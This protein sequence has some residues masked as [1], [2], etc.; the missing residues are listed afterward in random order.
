M[1]LIQVLG[2][3]QSPGAQE[4]ADGLYALNSM[5]D[6]W[7]IERLM[8]YQIQQTT[9]TWPANT[10]SRTIGSGGNFNTTRPTKVV[11]GTFFRD[12]NGY[13]YPVTVTHDRAV[14]DSISLKTSNSTYPDLLF[15]DAAHPLMILYVYPVP[16]GSL[17]LHLNT[18]KQLQNFAALTTDLSLPPGY[19]AAIEHNLAVWMAPEFGKAAKEA[20]KDL[21]PQAALLKS[22]LKNMNQQSLVSAVDIG[23]SERRFNI[24]TE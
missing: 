22:N 14:Y 12:S 8:V 21:K 7:G 17:T 1:R 13:D 9:H 20:A 24:Y 10:S 16:S 18:W 5:L 3:D 4:A 6:A 2:A 23:L 19:Q 15:F 11:E